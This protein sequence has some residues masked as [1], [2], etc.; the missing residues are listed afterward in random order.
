MGVVEDTGAPDAAQVLNALPI[1]GLAVSQEP[2]S[3]AGPAASSPSV[4][5]GVFSAGTT[6]PEFAVPTS[7]D[8]A[9]FPARFV[10]PILELRIHQAYRKWS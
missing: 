1:P 5:L 7:R 4:P 9:T 6:P 10:A 2:G 3:A 8:H